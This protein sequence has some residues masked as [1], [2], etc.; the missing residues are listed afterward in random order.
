MRPVRPPVWS[1]WTGS[2]PHGTPVSASLRADQCTWRGESISDWTTPDRAL[3]E[4]RKVMRLLGAGWVVL[5]RR[6][7]EPRWLL[8]RDGG[9]FGIGPDGRCREDGGC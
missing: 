2:P 7:L 8:S 3:S 4:A 5:V 9:V 6:D 1:V